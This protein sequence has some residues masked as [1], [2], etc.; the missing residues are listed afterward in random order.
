MRRKI[1]SLYLGI[2]IGPQM[3]KS[4]NVIFFI[5]RYLFVYLTYSFYQEPALQTLLFCQS[6]LFYLI[7]FMQMRPY[8]DKL[9]NNV[10]ILSEFLLIVCFY[11]LILF[12]RFVDDPV[13]RFKLG[14]SLMG[15][16]CLLF[17]VNFSVIGYSTI[18]EII[19]FIRTLLFNRK[20]NAIK[21]R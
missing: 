18:R 7:Y 6:C 19:K 21:R 15:A 13:L 10:E 12:S 9:T 14:W 5:R 11:H 3:V 1:G 4:F 16:I 17:L 2:K 8:V 20:V